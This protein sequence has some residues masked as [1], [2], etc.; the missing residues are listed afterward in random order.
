MLVATD[1]DGTLDA[2][3]PLF[4]H[5][6]SALQAAGDEIAVLTGVRATTVSPADQQAKRDYLQQLGITAYSRLVI[7]PDD[8][9]LPRAKADWCRRNRVA[10]LID[11]DRAN[12]QA[13]ANDC[14]VLVPWATRTGKK[15]DG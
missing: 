11:N 12:A 2:N 10:L 1:L 4:Q 13:A 5:V 14:L 3:P 7:F 9:N 6:L 15:K 8:G